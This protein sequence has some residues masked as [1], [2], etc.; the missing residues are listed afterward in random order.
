MYTLCQLENV[1]SCPYDERKYI[2]FTQFQ[3]RR[4]QNESPVLLSFFPCLSRDTYERICQIFFERFSVAGFSILERPI[5]QMY[6][7]STLTGVVIDISEDF[8]DITPILE[9]FLIRPGRASV[10]LGTRHCYNYMANLLK[11]NQGIVNTLSPPENPLDPETLHNTLIDLVK[12]MVEDGHIKVPSDGETAAPEDEGVTDIAAVVVAGREKAV[13]ESGMKK[14]ATAKASAAEQARAREIEAMDL[15]T[16]QF[17]GH[18]L[19][20]GKERH[21]FCEPFFDPHLLVGLHGTGPLNSTADKPL[22]LQDVV[23]HAISQTGIPLQNRQYLWQ[24]LLVTGEIT[25]QVRG[26]S[27]SSLY[28]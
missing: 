26:D 12:E 18:S 22:P 14:K 9:G 10:A 17:R 27:T 15:I 1:P 11:Y 24:G 5:A 7:T 3:R 19:T 21:R 6:A 2:L 28:L 20:V 13:I 4:T 23:A 25:R 16:V 8:T